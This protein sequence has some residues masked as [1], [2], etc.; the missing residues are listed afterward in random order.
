[1][2]YQIRLT[3]YF[4]FSNDFGLL[5]DF[6]MFCLTFSKQFDWD[7]MNIFYFYNSLKSRWFT[8]ILMIYFNNVSCY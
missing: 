2:C 7:I 1:M 6:I 8:Y 4:V 3:P 5:A